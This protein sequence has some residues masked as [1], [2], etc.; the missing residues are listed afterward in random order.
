MQGKFV[1]RSQAESDLGINAPFIKGQQVPVRNCWHFSTNGDAVDSIF[2]DREDFIDGMNRVFVLS[3][4]YQVLIL[5]FILM[6]THVHF[7]LYGDFDECKRFVHEF[8][9]RTSIGFFRKYGEA[10]KFENIPID[11]QTVDNDNYLKIVIAY[12]V[13]NAP[14]GGIPS[15]WFDYPWSSGPLYFRNS[16][17]WSSPCWTTEGRFNRR[18]ED[19]SYRERRLILKGGSQYRGQAMTDGRLVFPGEYVEVKLVER[20]YRTHK[21]FNYFLGLSKEDE[22]ESRGGA[23]S[24]LSIPIQEMRQHRDEIILELF[25]GKTIRKLNTTQRLRLAKTIKSRYN[26][27]TKQIVKL[28]GLIY[29]EA[30]KLL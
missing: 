15:T 1:L 6:D 4:E 27:S 13:R 11:Y 20:I 23:I 12:V 16:G 26:S 18:L 3:L 5:A 7:D 25:P 9:R 22:V 29:E 30:K 8:A 19:L 14:V 17:E 10:H 24:Q 2:R 28:T 21:S